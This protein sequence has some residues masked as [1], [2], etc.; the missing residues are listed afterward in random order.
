MDDV[1]KW[2]KG[3]SKEAVKSQEWSQRRV[4][5]LARRHRVAHFAV[6]D[7]KNNSSG[8]LH[9]RLEERN[10]LCTAARCCHHK[11]ILRVTQDRVIE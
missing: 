4:E 1:A 2:V 10:N 8:K 3:E 9:V 5:D 6:Y 7:R 11:N